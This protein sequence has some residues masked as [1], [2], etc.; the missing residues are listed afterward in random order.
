[1]YGERQEGCPEGQ[2]NE[3]KYAAVGVRGEEVTSKKFQRP[4]MWDI[5]RTQWE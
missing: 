1:M 5:T 2:E 4:G 3:L